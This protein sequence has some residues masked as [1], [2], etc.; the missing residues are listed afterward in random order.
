MKIF[1]CVWLVGLGSVIFAEGTQDANDINRAFSEMETAAAG[2]KEL[3]P[4]DEYYLGRA[5]GAAILGRYRALSNPVLTAYLNKICETIALNSQNPTLYNGYRVMVLDSEEINAF[6]TTGGH[7]FLTIGLVRAA[8]S[9]DMLAAVIAHEMAHIQ[10]RH[11]VE[12]IKNARFYRDL[13]ATADRASEIAERASGERQLF[14][15]SVREMVNT[16]LTNGYSQTQEFDADKHALT[17]LAQ[18]GYDP[19]SLVE[20]LR[21]LARTQPRTLSGMYKTHPDPLVRVSNAERNMVRRP[22]D[23]RSYRTSR[24]RSA[25]R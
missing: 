4:V 24:F 21:V 19:S 14:D 1:L 17:L 18:A 2:D 9:E 25:V 16:L 15:S 13:S 10:L 23:T 20:V 6:A 22:Q 11:S 7:I 12:M 8:E 3:T 5:V